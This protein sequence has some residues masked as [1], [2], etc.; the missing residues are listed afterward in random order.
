MDVSMSSRAD[1]GM[2]VERDVF[3]FLDL[4]RELRDQIYDYTFL[5]PDHRGERALRIERRHLKYFSPTPSTLLLLLHHEP[6]LLTRQICSEALEVLLKH[7]TVFLSCG[8]YVLKTL[9]SRIQEEESGR[10]KQWLKW[11]KNI[12]L[13]WVTFPNLRIYPPNREDGADEWWWEV[14]QGED[15]EGDEVDNLRGAQYSGHYDEHDYEGGHY[16]DN[17][18]EPE[19]SS[20]YP[21]FEP[22]SNYSQSHELELEPELE[23]QSDSAMFELEPGHDTYLTEDMATKLELLVSMEV[24][25]LFAYLCTPL[26]ALSS[27]T[28]PLYFISKQTYLHRNTTRPGF[29]LPLKIRY[30]VQVVVHA[31]L[32]LSPSNSGPKLDQ[33]RIKYMPWDIW[34]SM[35]PSDDLASLAQRGVWFE[36]EEADDDDDDDITPTSEGEGEAFKAVW[37][38]LAR[39]DEGF[40]NGNGTGTRDGTGRTGNGNG[41][42]EADVTF[43]KWEGDLDRWRVGDELEVVF[44]RRKHVAGSSTCIRQALDQS[45]RTL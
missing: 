6:L 5:I 8:P 39:R 37:H 20:L 21:S 26:F 25:P 41:W 30:W 4:P 18:Y 11:M 15:I 44:K 28:L 17:L 24:A 43:V 2:V 40:R 1:G 42:L 12:E 38:E 10:G 35:D 34:A 9:L 22:D 27:I 31:L 32:M 16:D 7:H 33:V 23:T 3:R 14:E 36:E 19:D 13:E 45:S 29:A